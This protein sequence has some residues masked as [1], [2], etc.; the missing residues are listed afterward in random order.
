MGKFEI[1]KDKKGQFIFH[2]KAGNGEIIL[3]SESYTQ[4]AACEKGIQSVIKN[5][6]MDERFERKMSKDDHHY[7]VLKAGN[8]EE[9]GRSEM[10][11][12]KAAMEKGIDSVQKNAPTATI[13][14]SYD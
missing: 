5:S 3:Q 7:F 4:R 9:I 6:A 13:V 14:E 2:L 12:S 10:Y 1:K 8:H 11:N